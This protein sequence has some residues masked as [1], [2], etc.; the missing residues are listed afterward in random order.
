LGKAFFANAPTTAE[1]IPPERPKT[2]PL[3]FAS[4]TLSF[5]HV[6]KYSI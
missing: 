4:F 5:I 1:S 6:I 2:T 3:D